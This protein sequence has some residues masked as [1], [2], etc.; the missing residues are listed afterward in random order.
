MAEF[1]AITYPAEL[2][3]FDSSKQSL[4]SF[5]GMRE[6]FRGNGRHKSHT[7]ECRKCEILFQKVGSAG[8]KRCPNCGYT[9]T[10]RID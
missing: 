3:V 5:V 1:N 7:F 8:S 4:E 2:Q 6:K 10:Q 9:R